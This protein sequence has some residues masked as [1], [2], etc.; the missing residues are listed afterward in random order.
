MLVEP[1]YLR[2]A[3]GVLHSA[4]LSLV[5]APV[6]T[7]GRFSGTGSQPRRLMYLDHS[8]IVAR[9]VIMT[10][11][12]SEEKAATTD[13]YAKALYICTWLAQLQREAGL[14][15]LHEVEE[16][17]RTEAQCKDVCRR[18]DNNR[19]LESE[20][21]RMVLSLMHRRQQ[22]LIRYWREV[23]KD[24]WDRL[25]LEDISDDVL[26]V[27]FQ[28]KAS[29]ESHIQRLEDA[30]ERTI[31]LYD[32]TS[33]RHHGIRLGMVDAEVGFEFPEE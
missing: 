6:I 9:W 22:S 19:T 5:S 14:Q 24:L 4:R 32:L 1:F 3:N 12:A 21:L 20:K 8:Q 30:L 18:A 31:H 26:T 28:D 27:V 17:Q 7:N 13:A 15:A 10:H 29:F 23:I 11:A 16:L 33:G 2:N 25:D